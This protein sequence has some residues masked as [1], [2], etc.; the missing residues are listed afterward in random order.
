VVDDAAPPSPAAG[1]DEAK[2]EKPDTPAA[3]D[4]EDT[5]DTPAFA[6]VERD[7]PASAEEQLRTPRPGETLAMFFARSS[8]RCRFPTRTALTGTQRST[9]WR[10]R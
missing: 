1:D 2:P 10:T 3:F 5:P 9:G 8:A 4:D 7:A 6:G